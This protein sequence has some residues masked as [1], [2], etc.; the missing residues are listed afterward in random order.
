MAQP[1]VTVLL[2]KASKDIRAVVALAVQDPTLT[3]IMAMHI[4]QFIEKVI[5]ARI[6]VGGGSYGFTHD[7]LE[8]LGSIGDE[9]LVLQYGRQ[10]AELNTYAV[11]IRYEGSDPPRERVVSLYASS[12]ALAVELFPDLDV[13]A[14][15]FF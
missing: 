15:R 2:E 7:L 6:L 3:G 14:L 10:M 1:D 8:L 4:Q 5:K 12:T 9:D 11:K 13:P